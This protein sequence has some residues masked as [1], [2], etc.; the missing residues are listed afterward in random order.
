MYRK[1]TLLRAPFTCVGGV[2]VLALD[3]EGRNIHTITSEG[4]NESVTK[5]ISMGVD[6]GIAPVE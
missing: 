4:E 6:N 2:A 1:Y 3:E 5:S